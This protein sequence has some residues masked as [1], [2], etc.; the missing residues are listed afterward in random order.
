MSQQPL[1]FDPSELQSL[2]TRP[3][4]AMM[5]TDF[6]PDLDVSSYLKQKFDAT[7]GPQQGGADAPAVLPPGMDIDAASEQG[8]LT[9]VEREELI[10]WLSNL[11]VMQMAAVVEWLEQHWGVESGALSASVEGET[12]DPAADQWSVLNADF[13][14]GKKGNLVLHRRSNKATIYMI[15]CDLVL[16]N[17]NRVG[18]R[19]AE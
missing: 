3:T 4:I 8:S 18:I 17:G 6:A 7:F 2:P 5:L 13:K 1:E 11:S 16:K 15:L 12:Y 9:P 19:S 10:D 14:A